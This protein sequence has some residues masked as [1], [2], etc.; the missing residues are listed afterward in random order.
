MVTRIVPDFPDYKV[1]AN[2]IV[3]SKRQTGHWLRVKRKHE[4]YHQITLVND[5]GESYHLPVHCLI[6]EV[7]VG[8]CPEGMICRHL[9]SNPANNQL[10]NLCWGT[11]QENY[12][13]TRPAREESGEWGNTKLTKEQVLQIR[14]TYDGSVTQKTIAD[15]HNV[16]QSLISRILTGRCWTHLTNP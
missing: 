5:A 12:E 16:S 8:P 9:D 1:G 13:D 3:Y 15:Q 6:L 10:A 2:G 4:G 11:H 7:F 14:E